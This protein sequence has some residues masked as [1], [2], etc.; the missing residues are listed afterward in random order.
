MKMPFWASRVHRILF[1]ALVD[2]SEDRGT[3]ILLRQAPN[4]MNCMLGYREGLAGSWPWRR[5]FS[6][7]KVVE[8]MDEAGQRGQE[9]VGRIWR[10]R[11]EG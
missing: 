4:L 2:A 7:G 3:R 5:L 6:C 10:A 9:G 8:K 11:W 1:S